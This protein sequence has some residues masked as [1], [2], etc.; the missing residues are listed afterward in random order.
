MTDK[1]AAHSRVIARLADQKEQVRRLCM[2]LDEATMSKR[3]V[4]ASWSV[5]E[6]LAHVARVQE[7]F[8]KRLDAML[9]EDGAPVA[10]YDPERDPEF[11]EIAARPAA[12]LWKWFEDTR[13]RIIGKLERLEPSDWHRKGNHPEYASYDVHFAMEYMAHH[14]AHHM[15][16]M[17]QRRPPGKLPH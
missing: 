11:A 5:K 2:D 15:Y 8:E 6:L 9:R 1:Q 13:G 3:T 12:S 17:F 16:Q 14:E 7:V 4:P 10:S